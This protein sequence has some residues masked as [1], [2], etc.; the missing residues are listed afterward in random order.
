MPYCTHVLGR[1]TI[2]LSGEDPAKAAMLK[3]IGNIL[4]LAMIEAL[5]ETHVFAEKAGVGNDKLHQFIEG[6]F[7]GPYVFYSD[8]MRSGGYHTRETV[9]VVSTISVPFRPII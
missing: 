4:I 6:M 8:R 1:L 2:D 5:A 3:S 7:P 9:S